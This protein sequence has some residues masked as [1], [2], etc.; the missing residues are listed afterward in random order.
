MLILVQQEKKQGQIHMFQETY[1][2]SCHICQLKIMYHLEHTNHDIS[3]TFLY[4]NFYKMFFCAFSL[5]Q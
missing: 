5:D 4:Q 3:L 1:F 2:K